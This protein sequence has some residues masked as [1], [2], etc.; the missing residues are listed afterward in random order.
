MAPQAQEPEIWSWGE[1]DGEVVV[2]E[3]IF[4]GWGK[5]FEALRTYVI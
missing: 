3:V 2:W 4:S 1:G 5:Y